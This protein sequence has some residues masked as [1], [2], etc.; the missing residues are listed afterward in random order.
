MAD[1]SNRP[2][3][4][5]NP[6][7]QSPQTSKFGHTGADPLTELARLIGQ[8]DPFSDFANSPSRNPSMPADPGSMSRPPAER[9]SEPTLSTDPIGPWR[10][11][12]MRRSCIAADPTPA[13]AR[14]AHTIARNS[15]ILSGFR[16]RQAHY[17]A[18]DSEQAYASEEAHDD[19]SDDRFQHSGRQHYYRQKQSQEIDEEPASSRRRP[20]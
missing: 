1:G 20:G 12:I 9:Q 5:N 6:Y 14:G 15:A 3:D 11:T 10:S 19:A 8:N 13:N 16:M 18:A 4:P 2:Y 17:Y 7:A